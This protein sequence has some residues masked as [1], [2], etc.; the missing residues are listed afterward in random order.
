M[1]MIDEEEFRLSEDQYQYGLKK[2][3]EVA[4]KFGITNKVAA[5]IL[6]DVNYLKDQFNWVNCWRFLE[7]YRHELE[8]NKNQDII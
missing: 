4:L 2:I 5:D 1:D 7:I 3:E 8:Q 6:L